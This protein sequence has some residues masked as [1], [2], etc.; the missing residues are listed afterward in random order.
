MVYNY[1]LSFIFCF[2]NWIS[3]AWRLAIKVILVF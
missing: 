1:P 2:S 3:L